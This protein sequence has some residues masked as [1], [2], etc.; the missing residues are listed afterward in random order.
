MAWH[1]MGNGLTLD[2]SSLELGKGPGAAYGQAGE[3]KNK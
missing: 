2:L 1:G 3:S